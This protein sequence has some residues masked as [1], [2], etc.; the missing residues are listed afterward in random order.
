MYV[1]LIFVDATEKSNLS[2][3]EGAGVME[4]YMIFHVFAWVP[5]VLFI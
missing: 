1:V 3:E 4:F 5:C 2:L